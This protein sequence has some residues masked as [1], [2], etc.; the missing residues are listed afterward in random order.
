MPIP[1]PTITP[2][3]S[4]LLGQIHL[5]LLQKEMER[6]EDLNIVVDQVCLKKNLSGNG[7]IMMSVS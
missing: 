3:N 4:L 1:I 2:S 5:F 6:L 7:C